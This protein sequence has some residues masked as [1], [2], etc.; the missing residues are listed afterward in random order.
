MRG[1]GV[2]FNRTIL[3][4]DNSF[5]RLGWYKWGL[6]AAILL[7]KN[8]LKNSYNFW[9]G[10]FWRVPPTYKKQKCETIFGS[11][12][13]FAQHA[14]V[15]CVLF[16][17]SAHLNQVSQSQIEAESWRLLCKI[18]TTSLC[19]QFSKFLTGSQSLGIMDFPKV[20][21]LD[22]TRVLHAMYALAHAEQAFGHGLNFPFG[23]EFVM[24]CTLIHL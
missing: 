10:N 1:R 6:P 7:R 18:L 24:L 3:D 23:V 13:V 19:Q 16:L 22:I 17:F 12:L 8:F 11:K 15:V 14:K 21:V 4:N 20:N 9:K 2:Y 5:A